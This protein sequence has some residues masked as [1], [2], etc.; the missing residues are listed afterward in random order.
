MIK[1]N[2]KL[3]A[4]ADF[5]VDKSSARVDVFADA[6]TFTEIQ[7][8]FCTQETLIEQYNESGENLISKYFVYEIRG[9]SYELDENDKWKYVITLTVSDVG[10][11][12]VTLLNTNIANVDDALIEL[13][14]YVAR[15]EDNISKIEEKI[16]QQE[17][18]LDER[19]QTQDVRINTLQQMVAR[20]DELMNTLLD[21]IT[22]VERKVEL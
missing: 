1:V 5:V 3:Y 15:Y 10:D 20:V 19:L 17:T 2:G 12:K 8:D 13:A 22:M 11:D 9:I 6:H 16:N 4:D 14:E 18:S 7:N 21:R